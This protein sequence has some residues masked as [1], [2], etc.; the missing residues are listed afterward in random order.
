MSAGVTI[1]VDGPAASGKSTLARRLAEALGFAFLDTGLLYRAVG[2]QLIAAGISP[3]DEPAAA[4]AAVGIDFAALH[5]A[6]LAGE[7]IGAAASQV[8][9]LPAVRSALL[10]AQRRF[11]SQ[12]P[13]AV[14]AGRD[15]GTVVCPEARLKLFVTASVEE[16]ARRRYEELR[17]AGATPM[18]AAVLDEI[19]ARDRRDSER[20]LAP[21]RAADDAIHLDTTGLDA[22]GAFDAALRIVRERLEPTSIGV[23]P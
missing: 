5:P 18:K 12:P 2:A 14:L 22:V 15:V 17:A 20:A 16:R 21:L 8:A 6:A 1:A 9:I 3:E 23:Q 4:A 11:A 19:K 10:A 13:G 7:R